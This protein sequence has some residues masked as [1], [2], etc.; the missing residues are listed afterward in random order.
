M[1]H[2][3]RNLTRLERKSCLNWYFVLL[4]VWSLCFVSLLMKL[5]AV[6]C[7]EYV[8]H[9][10]FKGNLKRNRGFSIVFVRIVIWKFK[11]MKLSNVSLLRINAEPC[12]DFRT[13]IRVLRALVQISVVRSIFLYCSWE[14]FRHFPPYVSF[15]IYVHTHPSDVF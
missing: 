15:T 11:Q 6:N 3:R 9:A 10:N 7:T 2:S 13:E 12:F 1:L 14:L 8:I 5:T 4:W